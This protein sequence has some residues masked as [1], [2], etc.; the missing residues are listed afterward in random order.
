MKKQSLKE[1]SK[2]ERDDERNRSRG[3]REGL[4]FN[5]RVTEF[6]DI[7]TRIR[8]A[9]PH[10][11]SETTLSLFSIPKTYS[12][13]YIQHRMRPFTILRAEREKRQKSKLD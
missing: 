1:K 7:C 9:V 11:F 13:S 12:S 3:G 10:S 5:L 2:K 6:T 4:N 8:L